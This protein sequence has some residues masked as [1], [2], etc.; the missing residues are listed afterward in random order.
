VLADFLL[1]LLVA[2]SYEHTRAHVRARA[3]IG[4][5]RGFLQ[6][7][8]LR[9]ASSLTTHTYTPAVDYLVHASFIGVSIAPGPTQLTLHAR[10][11][12]TADTRQTERQH[13]TAHHTVNTTNNTHRGTANTTPGGVEMFSLLF[14]LLEIVCGGMGGC[15]AGRALPYRMFEPAYSRARVEVR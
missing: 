13:S 11:K 3:H 8:Y 6:I 7:V 15:V 2:A 5:Q 14:L 9:C 12:Q 10:T 1:L 4:Q